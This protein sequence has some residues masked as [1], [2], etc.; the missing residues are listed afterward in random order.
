MS[1]HVTPTDRT[2]HVGR[3]PVGF[4]DLEVIACVYGPRS[5]PADVERMQSL[6]PGWVRAIAR[7]RESG[8]NFLLLVARTFDGESL[9]E[10]AAVCADDRATIEQAIWEAMAPSDSRLCLLESFEPQL[11]PFVRTL[12]GAA[13]QAPGHG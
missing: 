6:G 3:G 2:R 11:V 1:R 7:W 9:A 5:S 4:D 12:I 8:T 13:R 10:P